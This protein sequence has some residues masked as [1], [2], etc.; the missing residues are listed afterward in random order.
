MQNKVLFALVLKIV[1][2]S[3][4]WVR[5]KFKTLFL[6]RSQM[7]RDCDHCKY[8]LDNETLVYLPIILSAGK[9]LTTLIKTYRKVP[10]P[11]NLAYTMS[12]AQG[13]IKQIWLSWYLMRCV[14]F[15][16]FCCK[17]QPPS[18]FSRGT[19]HEILWLLSLRSVWEFYVHAFKCCRLFFFFFFVAISYLYQWLTGNN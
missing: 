6:E 15:T 10:T 5:T 14:R 9:R 19:D 17:I 3:D 4:T 1:L 7:S 18:F 12:L 13:Q 8:L 2:L 11:S 16:R